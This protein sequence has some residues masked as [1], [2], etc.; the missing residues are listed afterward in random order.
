MVS[1]WNHWIHRRMPFCVAASYLAARAMPA[2][3]LWIRDVRLFDV[4]A[5]S[6]RVE[7]TGPALLLAIL[8]FNA[9]LRARP[10]RLRAIARRPSVV[11]AGLFANMAIPLAYLLA[12]TPI[13]VAWHSP[14]EASNLLVGLTLVAA[15]PIAGSSTGWAQN[16]GADMALSL[17]L[18]VGSTLASPL[19]TPALLRFA[20]LAASGDVAAELQALAGRGTGVFLTAWVLI[21]SLLGMLARRLAPAAT[22]ERLE[23][24]LKP[25]ATLVLLVLCY[26]NASACLPQALANPDWDFLGVALI[27][28][29]GLCVLTFV[30]GYAIGRLLGAGRPQR[31][32]LMFGMGMNNN[33]TGLVLASTILASQPL[34]LL[35]IIVYNLVQHIVAGCVGPL[36]AADAD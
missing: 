14:G 25:A 27:A 23:A 9:G 22:V 32:A 20:G 12:L 24:V 35:P 5:G 28:S 34:V 31:A 36:C 33:G 18:V 10:D 2:F 29:T 6:V 16:V 3:G 4:G 21:P 19:A 26:S 13:L 17:G 7:A 11:L 8:L 15:M 30:G 1:H